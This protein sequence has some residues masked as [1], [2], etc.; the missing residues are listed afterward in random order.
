[1]HELR[2]MYRSKKCNGLVQFGYLVCSYDRRVTGGH[3]E[4]TSDDH[5]YVKY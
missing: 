2:L 1:M 3:E 5:I 4:G